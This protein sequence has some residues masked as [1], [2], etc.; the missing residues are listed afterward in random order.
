MDNKQQFDEVEPVDGGFDDFDYG[1][2]GDDTQMRPEL[3]MTQ[4]PENFTQNPGIKIH[5]NFT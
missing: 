4:F 2:E 3:M 5:S 1:A